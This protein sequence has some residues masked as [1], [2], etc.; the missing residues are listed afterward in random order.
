[1]KFGNPECDRCGQ[2]HPIGL[3]CEEMERR[4]RRDE[5]DPQN[6]GVR[7]GDERMETTWCLDCGGRFT[8]REIER[9]SGCPKCHSRG[10][11][12]STREDVRVEV[13]WHELRVLGI[14]AEN[15]AGRSNDPKMVRTVT[16]IARRLQRQHP[17][18]APLTL[19]A[20]I[21]ALP[22]ALAKEGIEI[23]GPIE[24]HGIAD[25]QPIPIN[26]PGAVGHVRD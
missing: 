16:A 12:C 17:E 21:A 23:G 7:P 20:E 19:S 2:S 13:N 1:M 15:W 26:G 10:V 18:L 25:P 11:P 24:K 14:W 8:E 5:W 9:V 22:A 4:R 6:G 3:D